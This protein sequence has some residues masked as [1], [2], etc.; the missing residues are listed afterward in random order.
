MQTGRMDGGTDRLTDFQPFDSSKRPVPVMSIHVPVFH[1]E[2][3]YITQIKLICTN[4]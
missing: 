3:K 4:I 1:F 2:V